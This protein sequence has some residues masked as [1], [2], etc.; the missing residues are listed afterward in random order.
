MNTYC[1]HEVNY[2]VI[3]IGNGTNEKIETDNTICEAD[4]CFI[5]F[6]SVQPE[7]NYTASVTAT[8]ILGPSSPAMF[9]GIICKSVDFFEL[10]FYNFYLDGSITPMIVFKDCVTTVSCLT[11]LSDVV[12]CTVQYGQNSLM[13]SDNLLFDSTQELNLESSKVYVFQITFNIFNS[14]QLQVVRQN[15]T[16]GEGQYYNVRW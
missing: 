16:T 11:P 3:L 13:F 6:Q 10:N 5:L 7:K 2:T 4:K 9:H 15:F 12:G 8:S 14:E 1:T